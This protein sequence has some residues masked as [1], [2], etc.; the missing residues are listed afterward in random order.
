MVPEKRFQLVRVRG[1]QV[2]VS[3]YILQLFEVFPVVELEAC[4]G[5]QYRVPD[6]LN[7]WERCPEVLHDFF[8]CVEAFDQPDLD[9]SGIEF[10]EQNIALADDILWCEPLCPEVRVLVLEGD[11]TAYSKSIYPATFERLDVCRHPGP[12]TLVKPGNA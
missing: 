1:D 8:Q 2:Y 3:K 10:P 12:G 7:L 6:N 5:F 11:G 4:A 9:V